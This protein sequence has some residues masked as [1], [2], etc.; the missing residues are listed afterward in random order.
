MPHIQARIEKVKLSRSQ[1]P[2]PS[3][4]DYAN[5]PSLFTQDRQ[6]E[7]DYIAIP[8]VSSERREYIPVG[9]INQNIIAS[10]Q[11]QIIRTPSMFIL[12]LIMTRIYMAWMKTISGRL[13]SD[14]RHSPLV[15]YSFIWPQVTDDQKSEVEHLAQNILDARAQFP[16]SSLADLYDPLTMP[17]ALSK[18]HKALDKYVD[19]LYQ[20]SGFDNDAARVAHLFELYKKATHE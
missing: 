7:T 20:K 11:L 10:N 1:S 8:E 12:G 4:R 16:G 13:K 5:Y 14:Y 19:K 3:V 17:P 6:P 18:T 2:T 15:F 9:Y